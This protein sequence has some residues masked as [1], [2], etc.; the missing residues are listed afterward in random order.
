MN[1]IYADIDIQGKPPCFPQYSSVQL[2]TPLQLFATPWTVGFQVSLS[3]GILQARILEWIAM[4]S[5]R[6]SS[7]PRDQAQVSCNAGGC[8]TD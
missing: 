2:L 8:F 6:R 7:H 5:S 4:S 1:K 3:V